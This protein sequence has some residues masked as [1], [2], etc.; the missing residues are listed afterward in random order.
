MPDP[1]NATCS[2]AAVYYVEVKGGRTVGGYGYQPPEWYVPCGVF[3]AESAGQ[4]K[5]MLVKHEGNLDIPDDFL[6]MRVRKLGTPNRREHPGYLGDR[7]RW[8]GRIP[9]EAFSERDA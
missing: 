4:A 6:A 8:W 3:C 7:S 2:R 5:G 1:S 9:E